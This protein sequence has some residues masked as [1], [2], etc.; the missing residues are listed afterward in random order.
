MESCRRHD[1]DVAAGI[2]VQGE[3]EDD[4]RGAQARDA[5]VVHGAARHLRDR[6]AGALAPALGG[7]QAAGAAL[8]KP[9]DALAASAYRRV[10]WRLHADPEPRELAREGLARGR[11]QGRRPAARRPQ[12]RPR[13]AHVATALDS[14]VELEPRRCDDH[15][16]ADHSIALVDVQDHLDDRIRRAP[17]DRDS[18]QE[19]LHRGETLGQTVVGVREALVRVR[20][21]EPPQVDAAGVGV[22]L[23]GHRVRRL[24]QHRRLCGWPV[25]LER[26]LDGARGVV[27]NGDGVNLA[28]ADDDE[29][30]GPQRVALLPLRALAADDEL[31]LR[32]DGL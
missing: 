29:A 31:A 27:E 2:D 13:G 16:F 11:G 4:L 23:E 10:L 5:G 22:D 18:Q 6:K 1:G 24:G 3:G 32:H 12:R 21:V 7:A 15:E 30:V 17:H 8:D 9:H 28:G 25:R 26:G 14:V 19:V 20:C